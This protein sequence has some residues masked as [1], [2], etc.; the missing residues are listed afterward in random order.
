MH[1]KIR[2][3]AEKNIQEFGISLIGVIESGFT[4]SI[5]ANN[6]QSPDLYLSGL[7]YE[8]SAWIINN[9]F[10]MILNGQIE[11]ECY[12]SGLLANNLKIAIVKATKEYELKN[13]EMVQANSYYNS[14]LFDVYQIFVPDING[15]F[16]WE[17]NYE[18]FTNGILKSFIDKDSPHL[19]SLPTVDVVELSKTE[20]KKI[21]KEKKK[22][23]SN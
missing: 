1:P 20:L 4:Y 6:L 15:N 13:N 19:K 7:P 17:D 12:I 8:T 22:S 5:G 16:L 11:K 9:V 21:V 23:I 18:D 2:K 10:G 14:G 3:D